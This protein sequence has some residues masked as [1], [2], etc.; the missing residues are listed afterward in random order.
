M[1]RALIDENVQLEELN[2]IELTAKYTYL[3]TTSRAFIRKVYC[4][5]LRAG[6]SPLAP[7]S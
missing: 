4:P 2:R 1:N 3:P 6:V 5:I 7:A